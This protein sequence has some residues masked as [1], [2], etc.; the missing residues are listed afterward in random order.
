MRASSWVIAVFAAQFTIGGLSG[1][2]V[3]AGI[4]ND[5]PHAADLVGYHALASLAVGLAMCFWVL[6]RDA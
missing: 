5:H 6:L 2:T 1:L 3:A 4:E